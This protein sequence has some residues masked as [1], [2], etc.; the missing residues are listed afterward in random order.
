M[1]NAAVR[2][3][4]TEV[5]RFAGSS[6]RWLGMVG[7]AM[8]AILVVGAAMGDLLENRRLVL[9]AL[10]VAA[11]SW[12]CLVRPVAAAHQNGLLLRNMV[13]DVTVPWS[14]VRRCA[15]NQTLQVVTD[16]DVY[17]GLGVT[18]SARMMMRE[19]YGRQSLV[20][21]FGSKL[22]STDTTAYDDRLRASRANQEQ[23][24][25]SYST[26]VETRILDF[27]ARAGRDDR[28]AVVAPAVPPLAALGG[29]MACLLLMFL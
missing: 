18:R 26:Y 1:S 11:L 9:G 21:G 16:D 6:G 28:R 8:C 5:E 7:I 19:T 27:A 2:A 14:K 29:A 4:G 24:G 23:A 3:A 17:H 20:G 13:R 10:I 15:V 25:G 12:V 22:M